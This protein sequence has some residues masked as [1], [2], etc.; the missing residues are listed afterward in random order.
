MD[1]FNYLGTVFNYTGSFVLNQS[2]IAGKGL[3][4][5]N[6]L[7][8]NIKDLYLKPSTICQL[9]DSFVT[10]ILNYACEVWGFGK[11]KELERIHLKFCKSLLHVKQST[12]TVAVYGELHRIPL[13]IN[14]HVRII[15]YWCNIVNSKNIIVNTLYNSLLSDIAKGKTNWAANVKSLLDNSGYS[16]VWLDPLSVNLNNF[17]IVFK[18]RLIDQF[19]QT[20]YTSVQISPSLS[21]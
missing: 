18:Q 6:V 15:K 5:L 19:K 10:S 7:R 16:N 21:V 3:K 4:A 14:R 9:F 2:T 13:Y 11:N 20:W 1:N 12:S 8:C 17:Y